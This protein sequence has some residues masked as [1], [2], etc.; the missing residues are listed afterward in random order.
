MPNDKED[1]KTADEEG[2]IEKINDIDFDMDE[3][4]GNIEMESSHKGNAPQ[5]KLLK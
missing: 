3:R 5:R 2:S 4:I 1:K